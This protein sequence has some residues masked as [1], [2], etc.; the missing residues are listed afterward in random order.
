MKY[1]KIST[2]ASK[3]ILTTHLLLAIL[4]NIIILIVSFIIEILIDNRFEIAFNFIGISFIIC[5]YITAFLRANS[6]INNYR[7]CVT[8][9]KIEVIKGVL[10]VSRKIMLVNRIFK[11]E[12]KR[13]IIGRLFKVACIKFYSNGGSIKICYIDYDEVEIVENV[14]KKECV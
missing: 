2:K 9:N 10:I 3:Y 4:I 11:I 7:Y 12:V 8:Q 1:K 5:I 13:G 6:L 14:I